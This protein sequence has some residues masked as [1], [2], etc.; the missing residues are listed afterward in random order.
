MTPRILIVDD[1]PHIVAVLSEALQAAGFRADGAADGA[2][3]LALV[4]DKLYDAA[5]VDF[6]L[7]DMNGLML[8]NRIRQLDP[9]LA[10]RSLFVSGE[11][12][13]AT[14]LDYYA[15]EG[16]SFFRKPF[17]VL[18]IVDAVRGMLDRG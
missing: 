6:A 4:K 3:A 2:T 15:A 13:S 1:E 7:P 16:T 9:E 11:P 5:I 18:E 17:D 10:V 8:H 12:Q 14:S